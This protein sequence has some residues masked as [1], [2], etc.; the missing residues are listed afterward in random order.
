MDYVQSHHNRGQ[1]DAEENRMYLFSR[2]V[3]FYCNPLDRPVWVET[4]CCVLFISAYG[5]PFE[6]DF[7]AQQ[8]KSRAL[9]AGPLLRRKLMAS[10]AG[11]VGFYIM[12][13]S[14][15]FAYLV[16]TM[17]AH[18]YWVIDWGLMNEVNGELIALYEGRADV[19][20]TLK[21]SA[22][23]LRLLAPGAGVPTG[24]P[25]ARDLMQSVRAQPDISLQQMAALHRISYTRM[26]RVFTRHVGLSFR[27]YKNW[28]KHLNAIRLMDT[29]MSLTQVAQEAGF[30]DLAQFTRIYK[31]WYGNPPSYVRQRKNIKVFL[32]PELTSPP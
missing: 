11:L 5:I 4:H 21:A 13:E 2:Q 12:P 3:F 14:P 23:L 22:H 20:Q 32:T 18:G 25:T 24:T 6:V 28:L 31:R 10:R 27:E 19:Q 9:L 8:A 1:E 26:S 30:A 16:N 17:P 15:L 29:G 7:G